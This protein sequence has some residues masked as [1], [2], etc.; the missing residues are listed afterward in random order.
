MLTARLAPAAA[1]PHLHRRA[2][3]GRQQLLLAFC[4]LQTCGHARGAKQSVERQKAHALR[5]REDGGVQR[6]TTAAVDVAQSVDLLE[7]IPLIANLPHAQPATLRG[8]NGLRRLGRYT[9]GA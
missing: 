7:A 3:T 6:R 8:I 5:N 2:R 4:L 9:S 1:L